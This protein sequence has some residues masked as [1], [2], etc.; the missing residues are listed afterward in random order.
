MKLMAKIQGKTIPL[1]RNDVDTDLII[2]AEY[3]TGVTKS[4]YGKN[5]FKRLRENDTGFVFNQSLYKGAN[6]LIID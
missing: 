2:P 1:A 4:G 5:L 3:L 6:I